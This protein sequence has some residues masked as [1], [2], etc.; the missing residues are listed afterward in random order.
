MSK[1]SST[2]R[3]ALLLLSAMCAGY[4]WRATFESHGSSRASE[5]GP[6]TH[7]IAPPAARTTPSPAV[8]SPGST[9]GTKPA[10][11]A[12]ARRGSRQEGRTV[13]HP[14]R[15]SRVASTPAATPAG[16]ASPS[17]GSDTAGRE[18]AP[19]PHT[20]PAHKPARPTS[21]TDELP[22]PR[23]KPKPAPSPKPTPKPTPRPS[24]EPSPVP[25]P[26]PKPSPAPTEPSA[27]SP[28]EAAPTA[29]DTA[30]PPTEPGPAQQ[31]DRGDERPG[32]GK[33]DANHIHTGP[34]G[35]SKHG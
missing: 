31:D 9:R 18:T 5:A 4:L 28:P 23:P 13:N 10:A 2:A 32:W 15:R 27:G 22:K 11:G 20:A 12:P 25:A 35:K 19:G 16:A 8:V 17:R 34:P 6:S 30:S 7:R 33:G 1:A 26:E 24:P 14:A 21:P 29:G 3:L